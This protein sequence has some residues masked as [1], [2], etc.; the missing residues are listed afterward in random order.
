MKIPYA[1]AI[2]LIRWLTNFHDFRL[3]GIATEGIGIHTTIA[4]LSQLVNFK[5]AIW[6]WGH[7]RKTIWNKFCFKLGK[8]WCHRNVWKCFRLLFDYLAWIEHQFFSGIRDSRKAGSLWGMMRDVAGLRMSIQQ[9][10]LSKGVGLGLGLLC[11]GFKGLQEEIRSEEAS[12]LQ[13]GSVAFPAGQCTSPQRHPCHRR[14][15]QDGYQNSS[16]PSL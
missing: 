3:K 11:W 14:F 12:P 5:N 6:K 2:H 1:I 7:L 15:D 4:W 16:S 13:I 8:K 10:W 9:S